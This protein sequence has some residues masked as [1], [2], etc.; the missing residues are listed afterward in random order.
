[1]SPPTISTTTAHSTS[2]NPPPRASI[3]VE[4]AGAQT[5]RDPRRP[6]WIWRRLAAYGGRPRHRVGPCV[7]EE[8]GREKGE[9]GREQQKGRSAPGRRPPSLSLST[10]ST[11]VPRPPFPNL[12]PSLQCLRNGVSRRRGW[13]PLFLPF[14]VSRKNEREKGGQESPAASIRPVFFSFLFPFVFND[15]GGKTRNEL[16]LLSKEARA[17]DLKK[18]PCK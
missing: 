9:K 13:L 4:N 7:R 10:F 16:L 18:I 14:S 17:K 12:P 15:A 6:S 1:M 3:H 8:I 2:S 11:L 5:S